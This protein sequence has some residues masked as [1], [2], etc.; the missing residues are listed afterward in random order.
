MYLWACNE[1]HL[2][3]TGWY[4]PATWSLSNV[5]RPTQSLAHDCAVFCPPFPCVL[6]LC[7][8]PQLVSHYRPTCSRHQIQPFELESLRT[9]HPLPT[10]AKHEHT[11]VHKC[12]IATNQ[13]SR[14]KRKVA[15]R[16]KCWK[17]SC[18]V[19]LQKERC[20]CW[21]ARFTETGQIG[22]HCIVRHV[23]TGHSPN[24]F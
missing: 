19:I 8:R 23:H 7:F 21:R 22:C 13:H 2:D 17:C 3:I 11:C 10:T 12:H 15:R 1:P 14:M 6:L 24:A 9:L 16:T 5:D 18:A 4:S 20:R